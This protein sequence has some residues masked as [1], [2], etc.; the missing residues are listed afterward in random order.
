MT[1]PA[2]T[3]AI[4]KLEAELGGSLFLRRPGQIEL[5]RLAREVMPRLEAIERSM[6]DI[7]AQAAA[8]ARSQQHTIRLGVMCTVGPAHIVSVIERLRQQ[9]PELEISVTDAKSAEIVNLIAQDEIDIGI[10]AWPQYP[11]TVRVD[12]LVV[13]RYA[14]AMLATDPLAQQERVQLERLAG[15]SYIQRLG[16]EFDDHFEAEHGEWSIDLNVAFES[17]RE[18]W[19]QGLMLAGFGYAIV[20]EFMQLPSGLDKRVLCEPETRREVSLLTLRGKPMPAAVAAFVKI[21]KSHKWS[22]AK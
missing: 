3:R 5:T 21:A 6:M 10:A 11:E 17:E 4:Q 15:Q 2:L 12:P 9:I 14:V 18:D 13:E 19:I 7:H 1:Q 8:V 22:V 20:P 16:C